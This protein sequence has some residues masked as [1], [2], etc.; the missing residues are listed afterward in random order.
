[1]HIPSRRIKHNNIFLI[2]T[3]NPGPEGPGKRI[4]EGG[5]ILLFISSS[6]YCL[7]VHIALPSNK[8]NYAAGNC[9]ISLPV[10]WCAGYFI[11]DDEQKIR[12][13]Q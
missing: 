1:M 2:K 3:K 9:E 11:Y 10:D 7:S 5:W 13:R 4:Y 8:G 6:F 12:Q